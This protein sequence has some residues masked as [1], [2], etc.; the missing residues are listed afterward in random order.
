MIVPN[1]I[2]TGEKFQE[3]AKVSISK[4]E[5]TDFEAKGI[6][7]LDVDNFNFE[8]YDNPDLIYINSSLLNKS[9]PKL[10]ESRILEKLGG[11]KNKFSLILHNSDQDFEE[12]N[13]DIFNISNVQRIYTQN[14]NTYHPRVVPLPIGIAN[15]FWTHGNLDVF[16]SVVNQDIKKDNFIYNNF[17]VE[18]GM[19]PEYR[20]PCRDA[21]IKLG[22]PKHTSK[23]YKEFLEELS[24]F[25][26]CLCP[27]GNGLDTHRL[28]ECLYLKVIPIVKKKP[29]YEHF[30][31]LFP[32]VLVDEWS[33][34]RPEYIT[35]YYKK[36]DWSNWD[37]LKF[38][39]FVKYIDLI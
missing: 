22:L 21:T 2:I 23:P 10:L 29:L 9:K 18:G 30:S 5:H 6:T 17:T 4:S 28:W 39:N 20:V 11:F 15:S 33:E 27:S 14:I 38:N 32:M 34:L 19:R 37:L 8:E 26:F 24:S 25:K 3:L 7:W 36:A 1:D 31:K 16:C 12:R 13:L 35:N